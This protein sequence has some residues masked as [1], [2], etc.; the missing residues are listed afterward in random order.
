MIENFPL[1]WP[2][3]Q[4][5]TEGWKRKKTPFKVTQGTAR[6]HLMAELARLGARDIIL[7]TNIPLR[8][9]GLPITGRREPDDPGVA[10]YF[11]YKGAMAFACDQY[12]KVYD[13]IRAIGL[14]IQA[15]RGIERWGS[16]DMME[17]A[18]RGFTALPAPE[19]MN[20]RAI[21][22]FK[23]TDN[24]TQ[25]EV[26]AACR[27]KALTMHPDQGGSDTEFHILKAALE[28]AYLEVK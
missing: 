11:K 7:S 10:V 20:W 19:S 1:Y 13:N 28:Q 27:K 26:K 24:P 22:G 5:R 2:E 12:Q 17:R 16:S 3:G 4:Q 6:D 14:T 9:D 25:K 15:I 8:K 18:F 23:P 21:L